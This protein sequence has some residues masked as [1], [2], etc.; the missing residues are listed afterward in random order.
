[1]SI[2][3]EQGQVI[4]P[5]AP[6]RE[7]LERSILNRHVDFNQWTYFKK[8]WVAF[9]ANWWKFWLMIFSYITITMM[10][11]YA[12]W[13]MYVHVH[14]KPDLAKRWSDYHN[15][16][17]HNGDDHH[18]PDWDIPR[19][20]ILWVIASL[21][22]LLLFVWAPMKSSLW[23]AS[24]KALRTN[25]TLHLND[26]FSSFT[27]PYY[28]RLLWL[29]IVYTLV[30]SIPYV[31]MLVHFFGMLTY[32]IHVD[33]HVRV[34]HSLKF[35]TQAVCRHF[36]GVLG[37]VVLCLLANIL[38]FLLFGFGLLITVPTTWFA[39]MF[40]YHDLIRINGFPVVADN[41]ALGTI[42][43]QQAEAQDYPVAAP[44]VSVAPGGYTRLEDDFT[45]VEGAC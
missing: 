21:V 23:Q 17:D 43:I 20:L 8:G 32:G 27:C 13:R 15:G 34:W 24:F 37:F 4:V 29:T 44:V 14:G 31:G 7:E 18:H 45:T 5:R 16:D 12:S 39:F 33:N 30:S 10:M 2:Q 22:F 6:T 42:T 11:M 35:S 41:V 40:V 19:S 3:Q 26:T 25:S 36:C 38:G 9:K 1:M 28:C